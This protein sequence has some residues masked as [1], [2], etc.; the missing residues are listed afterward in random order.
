MGKEIRFKISLNNI[1]LDSSEWKK[2]LFCALEVLKNGGL[3]VFPTETSYMLAGDATRKD[4]M[5]RLRVLK[6]RSNQQD[7][8]V[9]FSSLAKAQQWTV[10]N[11][12]ARRLADRYL[13]GPLTLILNLKRNATQYAASGSSLG[14]RIPDHIY[15]RELLA[16]IEFPITATSANRHGAPEPYEIS[17]CVSPVDFVWDAGTLIPNPPS[18]IVSFTGRVPE[19]IRRG[20]IIPLGYTN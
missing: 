10:W 20:L 18:T 3:I 6:N 2:L 15:L 17:G 9:M 12:D 7:M 4:T 13:P 16:Q 19:I 8:S 14:I 5:H 11:S 1:S